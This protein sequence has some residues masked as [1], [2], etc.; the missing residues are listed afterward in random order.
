KQILKQMQKMKEQMGKM[1]EELGAQ[2]V[3]GISGGGAVKIQ[4]NGQQEI[5]S[6]KIDPNVVNPEEVEILEDLILVAAKEALK[7]SQELGMQGMAK[8]TGGMKIP[9]LF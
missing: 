1:Q 7:R 2:V 4:V 3:E 9:G 5:L 6:V 8:L